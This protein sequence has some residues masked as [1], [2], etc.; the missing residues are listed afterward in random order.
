MFREDVDWLLGGTLQRIRVE[1][2]HLVQRITLLAEPPGIDSLLPADGLVWSG[3]PITFRVRSP[4]A[5]TLRIHVRGSIQGVPDPS[6]HYEFTTRPENGVITW[7]LDERARVNASFEGL[8]MD[9]IPRLF[10]QKAAPL[11]MTSLQLEWRAE[12]LSGSGLV[13]AMSPWRTIVYKP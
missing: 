13:V 8:S 10:E 12:A 6:I 7:E 1:P 5:P 3:G 4:A 9:A 2:P 11:G